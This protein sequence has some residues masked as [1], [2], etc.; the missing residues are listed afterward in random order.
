MLFLA[1]FQTA[2]AYASLALVIALAAGF[3][4]PYTT[5]AN[6]FSYVWP[7]VVFICIGTV[8][9][10]LHPNQSRLVSTAAGT[11][12]C[13][14]LST[15]MHICA[16]DQA[17]AATFCALGCVLSLCALAVQYLKLPHEVQQTMYCMQIAYIVYVHFIFR[18][19]GH[20]VIIHGTNEQSY[21]FTDTD[22]ATASNTKANARTSAAA[23]TASIYALT[24]FFEWLHKRTVNTYCGNLLHFVI[25]AFLFFYGFP[26]DFTCM[27]YVLLS[28]YIVPPLKV[29]VNRNVPYKFRMAIAVVLLSITAYEHVMRWSGLYLNMFPKHYCLSMEYSEIRDYDWGAQRNVPKMSN[30]ALDQAVSANDHTPPL[31]VLWDRTMLSLESWLGTYKKGQFFTCATVEKLKDALHYINNGESPPLRIMKL[32]GSG[33][34][35]LYT[36]LFTAPV[37]IRTFATYTLSPMALI[38]VYEEVI[39][40]RYISIYQFNKANFDYFHEHPAQSSVYK[41]KDVNGNVTEHTMFHKKEDERALA[42]MET[43][44]ELLHGDVQKYLVTVVAPNGRRGSLKGDMYLQ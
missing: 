23:E 15:Y 44:I 25:T 11:F 32:F 38:M 6:F 33:L 37:F 13:T 27:V 16:K 4:I 30:D 9:A 19:V 31:S 42:N 8:V 2:F 12:V 39:N 26:T 24:A 7:V 34:Y 35:A 28:S 1:Y 43:D 21:K 40:S 20:V 22:T 36:L 14:L 10:S 5:R 41:W 18:V 29:V 3:F 17:T